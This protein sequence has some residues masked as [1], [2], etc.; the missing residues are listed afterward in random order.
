M[1]LGFAAGVRITSEVSAVW[2]PAGTVIQPRPKVEL[3]EWDGAATTV[4]WRCDE[5]HT[6]FLRQKHYG[7]GS[8]NAHARCHPTMAR[9]AVGLAAA[10]FHC[11]SF[12][13]GIRLI[14]RSASAVMV[15]LGLTPRLLAK[16]EPS[17]MYMLR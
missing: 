2:D 5:H 9:V 10:S 8:A 1:T 13:E 11:V 7:H 6:V 4:T 17:Q 15:K 3:L 16:T 14:A 12:A